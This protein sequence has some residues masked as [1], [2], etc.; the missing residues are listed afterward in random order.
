[1]ISFLFSSKALAFADESLE[2]YL[3][4]VVAENFFV[5]Y[6][7]LS[8]AI[9]EELLDFKVHGAFPF[10]LKLLNVYHFKLNSHFRMRA[11]SLL[12]RLLNN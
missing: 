10:D 1:M 4:R 3:L 9:R 11:L 12:E 2:S 7:Q 5:S 6:S 8:L